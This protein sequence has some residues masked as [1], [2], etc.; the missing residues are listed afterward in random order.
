MS[1]AS[2]CLGHPARSKMFDSRADIFFLNPKIPLADFPATYGVLYLLRRDIH[3]CLE[4]AKPPISLP[5]TMAILA[6]VDLLAKFYVG[7]DA[8]GKV[9]ERFR[10]FLKTY[11]HLE[12]PR[13]EET[14]Y[15]LRN[16]VLHSFGLY[17]RVSETKTYYFAIEETRHFFVH[18]L[19]DSDTYHIGVFALKERFE[20]AVE[21]YRT[22]L[23]SNAELQRNFLTM[24][25]NYGFIHMIT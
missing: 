15:Q 23:E 24:Y 7:D 17:S 13:D 12:S 11:F 5:G 8:R 25:Q 14:I 18:L 20:Q 21:W 9:G 3:R 10:V 16:S 22:A 2:A 4:D 19:P 6:G 1:G